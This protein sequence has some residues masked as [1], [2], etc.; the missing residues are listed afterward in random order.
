M[1][2]ACILASSPASHVEAVKVPGQI[3]DAAKRMTWR[4]YLIAY[5][6]QI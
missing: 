6:L 4:K 2:K 1:K 5:C 3:L